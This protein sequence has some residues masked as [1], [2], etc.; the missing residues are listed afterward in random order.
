M[1]VY[2]YILMV[3]VTVCVSCKEIDQWE[4]RMT[5]HVI[6]IERI[7]LVKGPFKHL[8]IKSPFF[9][10]IDFKEIVVW[11]LIVRLDS[12]LWV[13]VWKNIALN[14]VQRETPVVRRTSFPS[15]VVEDGSWTRDVFVLKIAF[16]CNL[17]TGGSQRRR[18]RLRKTVDQRYRTHLREMNIASL[19]TQASPARIAYGSSLV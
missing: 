14:R 10:D 15:T 3:I 2:I 1:S 13:T 9:C 19:S 5:G 17:W 8:V 18:R 4:R 12:K 7:K 6:Y 11:S 16:R